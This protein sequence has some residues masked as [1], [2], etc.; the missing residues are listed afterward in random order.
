MTHFFDRSAFEVSILDSAEDY[1][2]YGF[3]SPQLAGH[4]AA[5]IYPT[6]SAG[7]RTRE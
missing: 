4:G 1:E 7:R 6:E 3:L 5:G 2:P